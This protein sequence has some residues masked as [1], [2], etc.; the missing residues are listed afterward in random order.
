MDLGCSVSVVYNI[1]EGNVGI[2]EQID[3]WLEL[4]SSS[5]NIQYHT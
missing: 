1:V 4:N 5:L 3:N 2:L